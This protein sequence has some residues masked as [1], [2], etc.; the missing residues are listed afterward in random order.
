MDFGAKIQKLRK[1]N[2]LT[3]E[4]L[5]EKLFV[6][7]TAIS[8][9]ESGR[10]YP[11]IDS[12]QAIAKTFSV[13][14]DALLSNEEIINFAKLDSKRSVKK[15]ELTIF[16]ILDMMLLLFIFI[17]LFSQQNEGQITS[18]SLLQLT[19]VSEWIRT[20][21]LIF[22][23]CIVVWGMI[24]ELTQYFN[25]EKIFILVQMVSLSLHSILT[26]LFIAN[27]QPYGAILSFCFLLVKIVIVLKSV[28]KRT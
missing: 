5:A 15:I 8:K 6:S 16:G 20:I 27:M 19:G 25:L 3:Q 13:T 14:V 23:N 18:V 1:E 7:R 17:P 11:S 9:W 26:L 21:Y 28:T 24:E 2:N 22:I 4:Q 12:L 10:G